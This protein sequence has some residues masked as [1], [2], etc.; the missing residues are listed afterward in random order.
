MKIRIVLIALLAA[1]GVVLA[2][3]QQIS[4]VAGVEAQPTAELPL[5]TENG[6]VLVEGNIVPRD[7]SNIILRAGGKIA[8]VLVK[9]GDVV[10]ADALLLRLGDREQ[11][12]AALTSAKLEQERAQQAVDDLNEQALQASSLAQQEL[13]AAS[14]A[15]I[16]ALQRRDDLD[17]DEYQTDLDDAR[18]EVILAQDELED[19]QEE[20]DKYKEMDPD[21]IN[22]KSAE[23]R[24]EDAQ[25]AYNDAVRERDRLINQMEEANAEVAAAEARLADAQREW[26]KRKDGSPAADEMALARLRLENAV[27]QTAAAEAAL[28]NLEIRAPFAGTIVELNAA[29]GEVIPANQPVILLADLSELYVETTDLTE[30]DVV[31]LNE[32]QVALVTPDA[33]A[34]LSMTGEVVEIAR[35]AGRKG[36]DVIYTVRIKLDDPDLRLRWGM[37]V[38]VRFEE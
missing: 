37:T 30:R 16:E 25:R 1:C 4:A 26:E 13:S 2:G 29:A 7:S 15:L 14:S 34:D 35:S 21:N 12:E 11:A 22:Y 36:G 17:T 33:L 23:D 19:A 27:A 18:A 28:N 5:V 10:E 31:K 32:G 6:A 20:W 38:E 8:E 24:L 9:E 3:C